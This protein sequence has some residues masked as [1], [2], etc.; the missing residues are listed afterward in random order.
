MTPPAKVTVREIASAAGV[1]IA[2]VSRVL[3]QPALVQPDKRDAVQRALLELDYIP[4]RHARSLSSQRSGAVGLLVPTL[5]NP[6]FAPTIAAI[7]RALDAVGQALLIHCDQRDPVRQLKQV[8][9]LVERGVDGIILTGATTSPALTTLLARTGTAYVVQ[10]AGLAS[11]G[12]PSIGFDNAGATSLGVRYLHRQGHQAIAVLSGPIHNTPAVA[13]RFAG[14]VQ[15]VLALGLPLPEPW[16]VLT[17]DYDAASVRE[18]ATR[19][20]DGDDRPSAVACTGDILALGLVAECQRRGLHVPRDLSV[21]GCGNTDMGQYV[22]PALTT[23]GLPWGRMGAVAVAN[24][25][26]RIAGQPVEPLVVLPHSLV[27]RRSVQAPR[28]AS[29]QETP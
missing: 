17:R 29:A 28:T 14:A 13:D 12:A 9:H 4:N 22:E 7:E 26:A 5:A 20:L 10:D 18:G 21:I 27:E 19:L 8:R 11:G 1:S 16:R 23:I 3:N 25:L 24:L 6:L 2:T 15:Q